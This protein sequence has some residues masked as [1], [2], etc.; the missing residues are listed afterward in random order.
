M[1]R[2]CSKPLPLR[3]T[4]IQKL[5]HFPPTC[6]QIPPQ[7]TQAHCEATKKKQQAPQKTPRGLTIHCSINLTAVRADA[8]AR[9]HAHLRH[10]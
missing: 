1:L 10:I 3:Q 4:Y 5:A 6:I 7:Y 9:S 2:S 8:H